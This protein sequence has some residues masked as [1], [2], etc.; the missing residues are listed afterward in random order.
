LSQAA[1][2]SPRVLREIER[3]SSKRR[4][5]I[6]FRINSEGHAERQFPKLI[7]AVRGRGTAAQATPSRMGSPLLV[8]RK[9]TGPFAILTAVIAAVLAYFIADKFGLSKHAPAVNHD[10]SA[11]R[12]LIQSQSFRSWT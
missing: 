10:T 1:I 3:A 11:V 6:T 9:R 7:E 4:T 5:I 8:G 2:D 12:Q